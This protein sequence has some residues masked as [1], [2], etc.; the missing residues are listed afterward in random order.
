LPPKLSEREL[1]R[2]TLARQLLLDRADMTIPQAIERLFGL[3]SQ[4]AL[5]PYVGL[6]T[7]LRDFTRDDLAALIEKR[8]V[9]K[10][11]MMRA[12]LH[13]VTANDYLMFRETL[14]PVLEG[15]SD[16]IRKEREVIFDVDK[17]LKAAESFIREAPRSFAEISAMLA[18][19]MP[20]TDVGSMR[21]TVR[22]HIRL[23]QVPNTSQWSFPG[24]PKFTLAESWLGKPVATE[25]HLETLIKRYLAAFGPATVAD[26]QTWSGLGNL[27]SIVEE[28]KPTLTVYDQGRG[29]ELLDLPEMPV[30][31]GDSATPMRFLPEWD[32]LLLSYKDRKRVIADEHRSSVFLPGLRVAATILI[33]GVVAGKWKTEN[34]KGAAVITVTPFGT[35][36]KQ[37][38]V[39]LTDEAERLIRFVESTAKTFEVRF[40]E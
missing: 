17:V 28:L 20:N 24:N 40:D 23:V 1:N 39:A 18:E 26:I 33:D 9:V 27:K 11:T 7:R 25:T 21:Y 38:R 29:R 14:A 35:L 37:D 6:W 19:L 10:A 36:T 31:D 15:A 34:K 13:L 3:Q 2:A 5:P 22:T 16:A 32:N 30:I 12:T 4:A 8:Q